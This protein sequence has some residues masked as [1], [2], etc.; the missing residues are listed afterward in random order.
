MNRRRMAVRVASMYMSAAKP[1]PLPPEVVE[2]AFQAASRLSQVDPEIAKVLS[3][4]GDGGRDKISVKK[5]SGI[6]ASKLSAS[7]TTMVPAKSVGMALAILDGKM[8]DDIGAIISK[9]GF[10]MD[11]HHRW[12]ALILAKGAK[13]TVGGYVA[14]LEGE[15]LVRV[16]NILTK[17]KF[18]IQHGNAGKGNINSYTVE[19]VT[20][21]L[22]DAVTN[23]TEFFKA[24]QVKEI[25]TKNFGT[26]REAISTIAGNTRFINK[27]VAPWAVD[28]VDMPVIDPQN[29]PEATKVLNKGEADWR[30][31]SHRTAKL[32]ARHIKIL[33]AN[34]NS[35]FGIFL[36]DDLPPAIARA[37]ES[38]KFTETLESDVERWL[39]DNNM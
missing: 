35:L 34:R 5:K 19:N 12:S 23:G 16:L 10:I 9:D 18:G 6:K 2:S 32:T 28:R 3:V 33:E 29:L 14:D 30:V 7:Q 39:A 37:L 1:A 4:T 38:V 11:G 8:D 24:E 25:L 27:K 31:A 15:N 13:A 20:A 36:Y 22:E 26:V 21:L 17:G